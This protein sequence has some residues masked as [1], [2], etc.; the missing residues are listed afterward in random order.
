MSRRITCHSEGTTARILFL[1]RGVLR[2]GRLHARSIA[3]MAIKNQKHTSKGAGMYCSNCG[4][5]LQPNQAACAKCGTRVPLMRGAQPAAA[6]AR[7]AD[8][9]YADFWVRLGAFVIDSILLTVIWVLVPLAIR[10]AGLPV[11]LV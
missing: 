3:A 6:V 11:W 9:P 8:V 7:P 10:M 1:W 4:T 5:E 2:N